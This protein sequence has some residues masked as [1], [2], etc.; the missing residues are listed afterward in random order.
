[1]IKHWWTKWTVWEFLPWWLANVPVY[2]IYAWFAVRARHFFFFSNVNPAIPL[3]GAVGESKSDILN[4]VPAHL[5]PKMVFTSGEEDFETLLEKMRTAGL[6]FPVVAKPDVGERGFLVQ[7]FSKPEA[8]K[9]HLERYRSPFIVQE[10]LQ[11]PVE[12][13]VLFH[14]FPDSGRFGITSVCVKEF[15]SVTGD[16]RSE[17]RQLMSGNPRSAFQIERFEREQPALLDLVPAAGETLLLEP[18]GNHVRGTK[19]LNGN[20]L[21]SQQLVSAFDAVCRQIDGVLYGR[22]DLKCDS[23]EALN[24]GEF[25]VMELNGVFG[26][27]AHVYDPSHGMLRA[28][29]DFYRHWRILFELY[30]AQRALGIQP[31]SHREAV[32]FIRQYV[33]YKKLLEAR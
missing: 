10:F 13:T 6:V 2:G 31:T 11:L 32:R 23:V 16:G 27:P 17:V 21:I 14:R 9:Q 4:L 1:M 25:M 15:L 22:F 30:R 24:R 33:R 7:K 19:F 28:Y 12:M 8:L 3:G 20:H 29:R 18:I 26:E 5:K